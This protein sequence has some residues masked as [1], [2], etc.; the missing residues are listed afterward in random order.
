MAAGRMRSTRRL[1]SWIVEQ[2][3][4]GKYPGVVWDDEAKTMFRIPW[5]H[6]GKHDFRKDEDAALFKA[7][8]EFKGKLADGGQD[9]PAAWKTR[10]RCALNK[11]PEFKEEMDRAQLDISE[12]Y[13]V[14]RLV[15]ISEQGVVIPKKKSK[16]KGGK[17]LKLKRKSSDSE[18]ED[19]A[20]VKQIK[21]EEV[22]SQLRVEES[23]LQ[24]NEPVQSEGPSQCAAVQRDAVDEIRLDVRIEET[25][26]A[27]AGV[28]DS[29]NVAVHYLGQEVLNRQI[30]SSDVRIM[31]LPSSSI[32]PTPAALNGRFLRVPLPEPPSTLPASPELQALFTL[33]PFMEKGIVLTSTPQG[34]YGKRFCQGRIF[35]TG[36]HTTTS[37]LHRME[38]N[39]EPVLLFSK[40]VFKQQLDHFRTNGGE[41]PK[42]SFTLC[43]GEELSNAEDPTKKL[44]IAQISL[45][46]AEQQVQNAVSVF[47]TISVFQT[48]ASQSPLGEIT[49]NLVTVPTPSAETT[50]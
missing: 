24:N 31:Y 37:G 22:T 34:V 32:P 4:S 42:C 28:Q 36:P 41:P 2:V 14:Y 13:K 29:F 50:A 39:T 43:F 25:F 23:L 7:W 26:P 18:S 48:L 9:N 16:E 49:L 27:I 35:W 15:P 44:I 20:P 19:A 11:S 38:R 17:K 45:P 40:D 1:R 47:E 46:W 33:L 8:A 12:P 30:H 3:S 21:T 5:K 10:L 6:A